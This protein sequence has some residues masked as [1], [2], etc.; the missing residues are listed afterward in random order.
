MPSQEEVQSNVP[1]GNIE[2]TCCCGGCCTYTCGA[3]TIG[4]LELISGVLMVISAI[5]SF[6]KTEDAT[7]L[8]LSL[9]APII[10]VLCAIVISYVVLCNGNPNALS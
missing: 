6:V 9:P 3:I 10:S 4:V 8:G 1:A 7:S 5:I 2:E